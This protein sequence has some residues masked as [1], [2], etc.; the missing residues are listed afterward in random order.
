M[1]REDS[2]MFG[3]EKIEFMRDVQISRLK[4][5]G[6][7]YAGMTVRKGWEL[8]GTVRRQARFEEY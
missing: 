3:R 2:R 4:K 7:L 6:N 8:F 5:A 1:A